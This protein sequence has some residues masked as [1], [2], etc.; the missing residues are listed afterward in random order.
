ME[1]GVIGMMLKIK[2]TAGHLTVLK[3]AAL[4]QALLLLFV[5]MTANAQEGNRLQD[6]QVQT[7]PGAR[8]ELKLIMTDTAPEPLG[9]PAIR[10]LD[11]DGRADGIVL[12]EKDPVFRGSVTEVVSLFAECLERFVVVAHDEG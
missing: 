4:S 11:A 9:K 7:L 5:G 10:I 6:I 8:V 2:Q 1:L 3:L 12:Q